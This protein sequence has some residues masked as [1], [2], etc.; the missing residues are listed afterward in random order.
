MVA[1]SAIS[2]RIEEGL[3]EIAAVLTRP[4][5]HQ[6]A[7]RGETIGSLGPRLG[8]EIGIGSKMGGMT[9]P[10]YIGTYAAQIASLLIDHPFN[11]TGICMQSCSAT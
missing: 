5:R 10:P 11:C 1:P 7:G 2:W 4:A 3:E 8:V 6:R 9:P